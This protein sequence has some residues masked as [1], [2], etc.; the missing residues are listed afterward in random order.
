MNY[1][2]ILL[3]TM[4]CVFLRVVRNLL[5]LHELNMISSLPIVKYKRDPII[6]QYVFSSTFFWGIYFKTYGCTHWCFE[7]FNFFEFIFIYQ[8]FCIFDW[9]K[10]LNQLLNLEARKKVSSL[11]ILIF[12]SSFIRFV[13]F[14]NSKVLALSN[15]ISSI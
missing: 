8:L 2:I 14:S 7:G 3:M 12:N 4:W 11:V 9:W 1:L 6:P 5:H 15:I 10:Y 13:N